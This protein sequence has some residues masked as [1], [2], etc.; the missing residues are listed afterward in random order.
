MISGSCDGRDEDGDGSDAAATVAN[1]I[2]GFCDVVFTGTHW[3]TLN[4]TK[5]M[6]IAENL[7]KEK[8]TIFFR[9]QFKRNFVISIHQRVFS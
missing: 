5:Y 6:L 2:S 1:G 3:A 7:K 9:A 4:V 8:I